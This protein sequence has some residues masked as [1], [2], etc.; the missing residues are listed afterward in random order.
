MQEH[1]P[2]EA[3]FRG[4][5]GLVIAAPGAAARVQRFLAPDRA[6]SVDVSAELPRPMAGLIKHRGAR[7]VA[8]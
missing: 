1:G 7:G 5:V 6:L 3:A 2:A 8:G 4:R